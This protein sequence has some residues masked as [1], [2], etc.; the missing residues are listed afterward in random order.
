M[1]ISKP[2]YEAVPYVYLAVGLALLGMSMYLDFWYWP[3]LCLLLGIGC[4]ICGL[5]IW[6]RRRDYRDRQSHLDDTLM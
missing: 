6:L 4:L 1:W 3:T 5:V 2:V